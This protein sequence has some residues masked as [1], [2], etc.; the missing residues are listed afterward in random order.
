MKTLILISMLM[1][2]T[3]ASASDV[4]ID[5]VISVIGNAGSLTYRTPGAGYGYGHGV[6]GLGGYGGYGGY[7]NGCSGCNINHIYKHAGRNSI[8]QHV[9]YY[10][11]GTHDVDYVCSGD[12]CNPS[13]Y[14]DLAPHRVH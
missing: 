10:R 9:N 14:P 4:F 6:Y 13:L 5:G 7:N 1:M 3:M 11:G 12:T 2:S 8:P